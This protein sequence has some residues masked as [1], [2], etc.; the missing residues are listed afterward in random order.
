MYVLNFVTFEKYCCSEVCCQCVP[1]YLQVYI[2]N[3]CVHKTVSN[4]VLVGQLECLTL[5]GV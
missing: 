3:E 1:F 4:S 2:L 5:M